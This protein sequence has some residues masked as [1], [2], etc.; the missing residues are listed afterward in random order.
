MTTQPTANPANDD[1]ATF[2]QLTAARP[3]IIAELGKAG[4]TP[5]AIH[6]TATITMEKT[7]AGFT[8]TESHLDMTAKIPGIDQEKCGF[9]AEFLEQ[10]FDAGDQ[11]GKRRGLQRG[12]HDV[13]RAELGRVARW[14]PAGADGYW[15]L[16]GA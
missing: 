3:R 16:G 5:A 8:V 15:T 9:L 1:A 14:H 11:P 13:L 6:T 7:D 4:F 12:D 2:E 10:R